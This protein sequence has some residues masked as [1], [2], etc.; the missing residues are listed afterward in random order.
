MSNTYQVQSGDSLGVIAQ[1]NNTT[2]SKLMELNP[3]IS[4]PHKIYVGQIINLP[5]RQDK[6][7]NVLKKMVQYMKENTPD[8]LPED[9]G[10]ECPKVKPIEKEEVILIVGTEQHSATYGNKMMFPAQAVR[11]VRQ[12]YS[13]DEYVTILMFTDGYNAEELIQAEES[14]KEHNGNVNFIKINSV[15]E[16]ITH[17]NSGTPKITRTSPNS[18][19]HIVKVKIIKIFSHGLPSIFDFGLDGDSQESQR[20]KIEHVSQLKLTS[21]ISN[22]I[23]YSYACR[24]GNTSWNETFGSEWKSEVKPKDSLAQK[25]ANHLGAEV[26]AYLRRSLYTSTWDDGGDKGFIENYEQI[27][28]DDASELLSNTFEEDVKFALQG[29]WDEALWNDKGAYAPPTVASTPIGDIP[30]TMYVFEKNK[31][32]RSE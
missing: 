9:S 22:P 16:L 13:S 30:K 23:I 2:I 25:L 32:P 29:H 18:K 19:N 15:S 26:H 8:T 5:T 20:F 10:T 7:I 6:I 24:T 31:E 4:D 28:D 27:D 14:S 12:N 11:E 3:N 21:F 1:K 17:I